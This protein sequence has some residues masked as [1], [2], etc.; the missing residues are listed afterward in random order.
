MMFRHFFHTGYVVRNADKVMENM[1]DQFGI[2]RWKVLRLGE[3]FAASALAYAYANDVMI[4]LVEVNLKQE[5]RV[6]HRGWIPE[7]DTDARLN[8]LAYLVDSGEGL[9]PLIDQFKAAGVETVWRAGFG[10]VFSEYCYVDTVAQLG[11]FCEFV[12]LGSAGRDFLADI[13]RN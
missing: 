1:R 6:F 11:H 2:G 10:D 9:S 7:S 8:H 12:C 13:P 5:L 3:G 4:E